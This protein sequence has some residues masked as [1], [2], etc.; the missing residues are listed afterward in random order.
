MATQA[1]SSPDFYYAKEAVTG[2]SPAA[3]PTK[4]QALSI[5]AELREPII[6]RASSQLHRSAEQAVVLANMAGV[7][8]NAAV[9]ESARRDGRARQLTIINRA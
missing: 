8:L 5:P 4:W 3:S 1:Y 2:E 9:A 6:L 7:A